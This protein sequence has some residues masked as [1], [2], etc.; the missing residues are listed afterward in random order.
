MVDNVIPYIDG[1][2]AKSETEPLKIWGKVHKGTI[3]P[4][5]SPAISATCMRVP[6]TDGHLTDVR[7]NFRKKTSRPAILKALAD[8]GNPLAPL[9]LPSSPKKLIHYLAAEDRPQT[10]LDRDIEAG[11]AIAMGRLREDKHFDWRFIAL[12]H[13]TLRGAAGGAVLMAE[14]LFKK[15]YL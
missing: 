5:T 3:R 8:F 10:K 1:E 9:G 6:V 12:S 14:L 15:G 2:E 7:V 13:N 11:M 4:A